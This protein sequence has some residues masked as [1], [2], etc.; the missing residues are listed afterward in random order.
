MTAARAQPRRA[1]AFTERRD[2][3]LDAA[4]ECFVT[5]GFHGT[6][7]PAVAKRAGLS[8]GTLY[9]YFSSKEVLVNALYR[10]WKE[11][12]ARRVFTAFPPSAPI[13]EQFR[14]IW[15]EMEAFARAEPSAFAFLELHYHGSYLDAESLAMENRLKDFGASVMKGAQ[16]EGIIKAGPP[17]LL[18]ELVFGAF[19][20][21]IR[22]HGE[23]R[24]TL[25]EDH[26]ALA[27]Q[28]CW[29]AI[30]ASG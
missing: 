27:E 30:A 16:A 19:I 22:A 13:R 4:L 15:Y 28:A 25:T 23:G 21:M 1:A 7:V 2:E 8:V 12:I 18:M 5:Q 3:I 24:V 6:A 11:E 26:R 17:T 20:G 29:D 14:A 9:H 10:R